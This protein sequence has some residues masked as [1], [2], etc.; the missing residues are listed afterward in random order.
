MQFA[1]TVH[2]A[3]TQGYE[4]LFAEANKPKSVSGNAIVRLCGFVDQ[5]SKSKSSTLSDW[6]LSRH[7]S[8]NL[9][10][11]YIERN[12]SQQDRSL[13]LVLDLI[14]Q[15][16]KR[17][18]NAV[19]ASE[20]PKEF[21]KALVSIITG[22]STM[23][24]A[25]SAIKALD[26]FL[27][28]KVFTVEDLELEYAASRSDLEATD[29]TVIWRQFFN[30]LLQWMRIHFVSQPAGRLTALLYRLLRSQNNTNHTHLQVELWHQWL[31]DFL[32]EDVSLLEVIKNYI[33]VPLFNADRSEALKLLQQLNSG[34]LSLGESDLGTNMPA[35]LR[36]AALETG[37]RVGLVEEP[38]KCYN[39]TCLSGTSIDL[40]FVQR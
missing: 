32:G 9:F 17:N 3:A 38:G 7:V 33:F 25:K 13:K 19:S 22:S 23:P 27:T 5:C 14:V 10:N 39:L 29:G 34:S 15:L 30:D 28:K 18:S 6:A 2:R 21:L 40:F 31:L 35:L 37:K 11:F 8:E 36:L 4:L 24:V 12:E 20:T 16:L 26:H 1:E